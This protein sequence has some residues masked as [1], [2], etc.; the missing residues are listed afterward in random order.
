MTSAQRFE[1]LLLGALSGLA[2]FA[3]ASHALLLAELR[4]PVWLL[5]GSLLAA[6]LWPWRPGADPAAVA[7]AP[8][9]LRIVVLVVLA[10]ALLA[11]AYGA[12]ATPSRHWDG[13]VAWDAKAQYLTADCTLEQPF[14]R[15]HAVFS[16]SRDYPLLQP[17]LLACGN[18]LLGGDGGRALFPLI[19]ALLG[20]LLFTALRRTAASRTVAWLGTAVLLLTPALV[21]PS[22]GAIDSGYGDCLLLLCVLAMA[23]GLSLG[24]GR[25]LLCGALLAVMVKPEGMVY[26]GAA[27]AVAFCS[28][29]RRLLRAGAIGL[30][31]GALFWLPLQRHLM[32][33]DGELRLP[34]F[35]AV[36]LL[37]C[38]ACELVEALARRLGWGRR[39]RVAAALLSLPALA[40]ALPLLVVLSGNQHGTMEFYLGD[41]SRPLQRL[42]RL[43]AIAA[44]TLYYG[45]LRGGF[46]AAFALP[47]VAAIAAWRR[48]ELARQLPLLLFLL[49]GLGIV[50]VPFLLSQEPD[51]GHHLRSSMPRLQLHW[52]GAAVLY[53]FVAFAAPGP[54]L[55]RLWRLLVPRGTRRD[56]WL[57]MGW[58]VLRK[59]RDGPGPWWRAV[60]MGLL[61]QL[62]PR[63]QD[64]WLSRLVGERAAPAPAAASAGVE[65][66][67]RVSVVLPVYQQ[68]ALLRAAI[69]S[70]LAQSH[71]D[72]ELIVV[73]DGSGPDVAAV[74][75]AF[76]GEPRLRRLR[77]DNRGL[78]A[79]LDAGFAVAS[80]EYWT[81]TSADNLLLPPCLERLVAFLQQHRDVAMVFADYE[82]IDALGAPIAG[83]M[84][85]IN[86]RHGPGSAAVAADRD[87]RQ[88]AVVQDNFI[89]PCFLY[90][91]SAGRLLGRYEPQMG[92][93]DYDYW[94]R[95]SRHFEL[96]HLGSR[97]VL[98]RYRMH[99]DSLTARAR[100]LR[101]WQRGTELLQR[102]RQRRDWDA[103]PLLVVAD[104]DTAEPVRPLLR[105][106][107][108]LA[109]RAGDDAAKTL[110]LASAASARSVLPAT[111]PA[112]G[113][114][115]VFATSAEQVY[116]AA[117]VL[118]RHEVVTFASDAATAARAAV[119]S[120]Q[121]VTLPLGAEA[122]GL[123]RRFA[124]ERSWQRR[125]EVPA[126]PAPATPP[127]GPRR[128]LLQ[129]DQLTQGGLERVVLDAAAELCQRGVR[130]SLLVLGARGPAVEEAA[131]AGI[132][133]CELPARPQ[134]RDYEA[135]LRRGGFD[136]VSAHDSVFGAAIARARGV[137]FVQ[138]LHNIYAW[139][140][141][142]RQLA[143][144][145]AD[146][147][148][149]AYVAVGARVLQYAD[150]A[151]G[152]D[153]GKAVVVE[154]GIAA[155]PPSLPPAAR[156]E[157]RA[158]MGFGDDD[159][160]FLQV[161][162][163]GPVKAQRAT[164]LAL[165]RL[166]Q[167]GLPAKLL[168]VGG[169]A[170]AWYGAALRRDVE[171]L[172]LA[173]AAIVTGALAD[174]GA[175]YAL[176]DAFVLPSL[177]EGCSLA[178]AEAKAAGL[179]I[180]ATDVGAAASQL[181][182][183][184]ELLAPWC[185]PM[186]LDWT[187]L[188]RWL[189]TTP[190]EFVARLAAAMARIA[191]RRAPRRPPQLPWRLDRRRM[192]T[193]W[194][195][196][197]CWLHQGGAAAAARV[198]TRP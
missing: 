20:L 19:Y 131:A 70:V 87:L 190:D 156:R 158:R 163:L 113:A 1:R 9:G 111:L 133:L 118:G 30:A 38:V 39:G 35:A 48:R 18:R 189:E 32:Q 169:D 97:E 74:L 98:Y 107:D 99:D 23:Q 29:D 193:A 103:A 16:P 94:L 8:R 67:G 27:I 64:R 143:Y 122:V 72:L 60:R 153:V 44:G 144:R 54:A 26:G 53:A 149:A 13:A 80:G 123:A 12:L 71:R 10:T 92:L 194:W 136:L 184:D 129:A 83:G 11:I 57:W 145:D 76:A 178:L 147:H 85:R 49:A 174:A 160:V 181:G 101:L 164:L 148:T 173:D 168:L 108:R 112:A 152:L 183:G 62:P 151:L 170:D 115:A 45:L 95:L 116:A 96:R 81:W 47:L 36:L 106:G 7:P 162:A 90:R 155:A 40:L 182:S 186:R 86:Q 161:A 75:D 142:E 55:S 15:D 134:R 3:L 197:F 109:D 114:A 61:Q 146:A 84:V 46:G 187:S 73:D 185:D 180:V 5:P 130:V 128:V 17:L 82:L 4:V 58:L 188:G 105:P 51:L 198:W 139:F 177:L 79:A 33:P 126:A 121:V 191:G 6:V 125:R 34:M 104:A 167:D 28:A 65:V 43:P 150:L 119:F 127:S 56:R 132:E 88:L 14:F 140:P 117:P 77:Q 91:G 21:N 165:A 100:E 124:A 154:N 52:I 157:Q 172:G 141:P 102:E 22:G 78:P 63:L 59:L 192:V 138:T 110:W 176:A 25:Y 93:E 31:L 195:R 179:P 2:L 196:L 41:A 66:P 135:L 175:C 137:P 37:F 89:G 159:F 166:R 120:R 171:R 50:Q 68:A 24:D 69:E 42:V